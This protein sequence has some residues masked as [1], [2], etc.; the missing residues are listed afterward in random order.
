MAAVLP[1]KLAVLPKTP[2]VLPIVLAVVPCELAVLP[3]EL[4]VV[5]CELAAHLCDV[6]VAFSGV[7]VASW[8][9]AVVVIGVA[10]DSG[11]AAPHPFVQEVDS[12]VLAVDT[13]DEDNWVWTGYNRFGDADNRVGTE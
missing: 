13:C 3:C 9:L 6:S 12:E 10:V 4:A 8:E 1:I 11:I 7:E 2:A 5:P